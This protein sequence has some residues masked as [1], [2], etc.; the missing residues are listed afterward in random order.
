M[1]SRDLADRTSAMVTDRIGFPLQCSARPVPRG[2]KAIRAFSFAASRGLLVCLFDSSLGWFVCVA[3]RSR[4]SGLGDKSLVR[5]R[6]F[7][8]C[9]SAAQ[10]SAAPECFR[11]WAAACIV[12]IGPLG[13]AAPHAEELSRGQLCAA[14]PYCRSN[15]SHCSAGAARSVSAALHSVWSTVSAVL[16]CAALSHRRVDLF[17]AS[18]DQTEDRRALA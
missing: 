11:R 16:C 3:R 15:R 12:A 9:Q 1:G 14:L 18:A 5:S 10:R 6:H 13:C 7:T 17:A 4:S 8:A 2:T